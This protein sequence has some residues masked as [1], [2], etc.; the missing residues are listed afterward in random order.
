MNLTVLQPSPASS[1]LCVQCGFCCDGT[2]FNHARLH[3]EDDMQLLAEQGIEL[4]DGKRFRLPC[5]AF[6]QRAC[7][8]YENRFQICRTFQCELLK[9]VT[10][11]TISQPFATA[12]VLECREQFNKINRLLAHANVPMPLAQISA[13]LNE[14]QSHLPK[15]QQTELRLAF[16]SLQY[17]LDK[18]FRRPRTHY[19]VDADDWLTVDYND[20][21][22][23]VAQPKE[24]DKPALVELM[25]ADVLLSNEMFP[26]MF[27]SYRVEAQLGRGSYGMVCRAFDTKQNQP[28]ALKLIDPRAAQQ[29][30]TVS[31]F[32]REVDVLQQLKHPNILPIYASGECEGCLFMAL[33]LVDS[34]D[35][36]ARIAREGKIGWRA[37]VKIISAVAQALDHAFAQGIVHN[38]VKPK[39]VLIDGEAI[40]LSDFGFAQFASEVA[41]SDRPFGTGAYMAPEVWSGQKVGQRADI[42]ALGCTCYEMLT[43]Q[44]LFRGSTWSDFQSAHCEPSSQFEIRLADQPP[45]EV[46]SVLQRAVAM[47]PTKRFPNATAFAEALAALSAI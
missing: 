39:N 31:S 34:Q 10:N 23:A 46:V 41:A 38:D 22:Q 40:Y 14:L 17:L 26:F 28:V 5:A 47:Q 6:Q 1:N 8:I 32:W 4:L 18:H 44:R 19:F 21:L 13:H 9:A 43:G 24:Y 33:K 45:A 27:G 15:K 2:L 36:D 7:Q 3:N 25:P 42:Y 16:Y 20:G 30:R 12:I 35:L 37:T 29:S 11:S